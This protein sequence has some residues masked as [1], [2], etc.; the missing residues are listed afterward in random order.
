MSDVLFVKAVGKYLV[1]NFE[2]LEGAISV[3]RFVGRKYDP[4]IGGFVPSESGDVV[5][6]RKEYRDAVRFGELEPMDE[7]TAKL[8]DVPWNSK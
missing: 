1:Q 8:C 6:F 7:A 2:A 5:P 4:V 3:R